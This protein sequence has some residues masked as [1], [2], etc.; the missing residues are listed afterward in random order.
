[1][2]SALKK[3]NGF[4]MLEVVITILLS[5]LLFS[6]LYFSYT[7]IQKNVRRS[8]SDLTEI[9][10]LKQKLHTI[11][12]QSDS[13]INKGSY[14]DFYNISGRK[15]L[16]FNGNNMLLGDEQHVDTLYSGE[17]T[18]YIS[19]NNEIRLTD[20]LIVE[21][22]LGTPPDTIL[23]C[24]SKTYLPAISLRRKEVDFEY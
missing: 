3:I 4:T 9:L 19:E 8:K 5:L 10:L 17:Y 7:I 2:K 23:L 6:I 22:R 13:I 12:D 15:A 21:F 1:M 14:L 24:L 11:F 18:Y 16:E 20:Q